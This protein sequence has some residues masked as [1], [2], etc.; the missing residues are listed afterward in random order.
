VQLSGDL[1]ASNPGS[2]AIDSGKWLP[3]PYFPASRLVP[4]GVQSATAP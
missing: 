2:Y 1:L 3:V 4:F